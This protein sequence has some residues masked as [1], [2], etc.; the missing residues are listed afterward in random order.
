MVYRPGRTPAGRVK[1]AVAMPLALGVTV[2]RPGSPAMVNVTGPALT[3]PLPENTW[4]LSVMTCGALL[5][6]TTGLEKTST[7]V[8]GGEKSDVSPLA[9]LV[10]VAVTA[11]PSGMVATGAVKLTVPAGP[12]VTL[13]TPRKAEARLA[14]PAA[15]VA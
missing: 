5:E 11:V 12:V 9:R 2:T 10:A 7:C 6:A 14:A 15:G 4:A 8:P 13:R 3:G 1:R